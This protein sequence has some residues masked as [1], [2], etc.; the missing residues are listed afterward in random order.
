LIIIKCIV[1]LLNRFS[2]IDL[3]KRERSFSDREW[4]SEMVL[5][6]LVVRKNPINSL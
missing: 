4:L 1:N 3:V 5:K 6:L 2:A